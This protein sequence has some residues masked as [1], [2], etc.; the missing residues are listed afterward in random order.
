MSVQELYTIIT[1]EENIELYNFVNHSILYSGEFKDLPLKFYDLHVY[2][3]TTDCIDN[4]SM[5]FISVKQ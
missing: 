3:L 2:S 1:G 5:I 4:A